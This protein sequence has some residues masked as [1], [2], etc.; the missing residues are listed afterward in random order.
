MIYKILLVW[1]FMFGVVSISAQ[2]TA[3]KKTDKIAPFSLK[4]SDGQTYTPAQLK[5]EATVLVYFSPECDHCRH[6]TKDMLDNYN[7]LLLNKQ[8]VMITYLPVDEVKKFEKDFNLESYKN[9]RVGTEERTFVVRN[10]YNIT[11]FPFVVL[12]SKQGK[13][14]RIFSKSPSFNDVAKVVKIL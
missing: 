3:I 13:E 4:L 2:T 12:Y 9:I 11:H 6:F 14:V 7:N 5:K 1:G 10:Y 8:V